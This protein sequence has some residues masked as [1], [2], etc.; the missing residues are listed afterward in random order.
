MEGTRV[1]SRKSTPADHSRM[2]R[3]RSRSSIIKKI[4][5]FSIILVSLAA[6]TLFAQEPQTATPDYSVSPNWFPQVLT[7]YKPQRIPTLDLT[8]SKDL[9][10]AVRGGKLELTLSQL[11]AAVV[12]NNLNL[13]VAR[14]NIYFAQ[15]DLLRAKAGQAA[16]GVSAADAGIPNALFSSAIGAGVGNIAGLGGIGLTGSISGLQRSLAL[17]PA[18]AYDPTFLFNVSLDRTVS[19][20]NTLVVAGVPVVTTD[21]AFYQFGYQQAFTTGTSFRVAISNQRQLSTQQSLIYNPDVVSR[22]TVAVVQQL[23]NGFGFTVGRRFQTVARTNIEI[24]REWFLQQVD[25][26]LAQA[27]SSYWDLVSAQEQ[28]KATQEALDAAQKL[29]QDN[30]VEA[31]LGVLAPLDVITAQSQMVSSQR[32]LTIAQTNLQ[33]QELTLK[34]F[35]SKQLTDT[36]EN[37]HIVATDPLPDPGNEDVPP[38]DDALATAMR[39]RP[40]VPRAQETIENDQVAIKVTRNFL[41]PTFNVFG[42]FASSGLS[43]DQLIAISPGAA[44]VLV[45]GGLGQEL[46]QFIRFKYPEYAVGFSL[47]IPIRN[48]SAIADNIRSNLEERQAETSLQETQNLIEVQVRS[49]IITSMQANSQVAAT[50]ESVDYSRRALTA[51]QEKQA[52]GLSTPYDVILAQRNL[53]DAQLA[54][55][56]ARV[57]YAKALVMLNRSMGVLAEKSHINEEDAFRGRISQGGKIE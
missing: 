19:P 15:E 31:E 41:K 39:N 36:L 44:G 37:A 13:A 29:Y 55:V 46:N 45:R 24:V 3:I 48:R 1:E 54:D 9:S 22:M 16:R 28:V 51:E 40:E 17:A 20:L 32:D 33:Q 23:T 12:E 25:T 49:G 34:T 42:F 2:C 18:G 56:Q 38:I 35:F 52:A 26:I 6:G 57:R 30:K 4:C 43:G 5:H 14:Y 50:R 11:A 7:P 47:T 8:N 53:L 27:E 21:S 10:E